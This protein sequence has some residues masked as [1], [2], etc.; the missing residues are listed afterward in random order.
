MAS[1]MAE[2]FMNALLEIEDTGHAESM[3]EIFSDDAE[4]SNLATIEPM[5]GR[6]GAQ[7]FWMDYLN[8]FDHIRSQF[9]RVIENGGQIVLE[10][11]SHG[12][13]RDGSRIDYRGVS[14]LE[15]DGGRVRRFHAYYDTAMFLKPHHGGD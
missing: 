1:E 10:W 2:K 6:D 8:V 12:A 5:R 4:V 9:T 15:T 13:L 14:V 11:N 3:A 7:R